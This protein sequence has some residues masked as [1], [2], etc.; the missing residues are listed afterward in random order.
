M[1]EVREQNQVQQNTTCNIQVR[2]PKN[3]VITNDMA[4]TWMEWLQQFNWYSTAVQ[5]NTQSAERQAATLMATIGPDAITIFNTFGLSAEE[6]RNVEVIKQKFTDYFLPKS[7]VT[8]ER[9]TF[10]KM[11]QNADETFTEFLTRIKAQSKKCDFDQLNDSLL[12]DKI[13]IGVKSESIREKLS[14]EDNLTL[15]R[16]VTIALAS[17]QASK[18]LKEMQN[19]D[20]QKIDVIKTNKNRNKDNQN[21]I[22]V[23]AKES[24]CRRCG[25]KHMPRSCPAFGKNCNKCGKS[26][27]FSTVCKSKRKEKSQVQVVNCRDADDDSEEAFFIACVN[28][29]NNQRILA[30]T[31][32]DNC[33]K[34]H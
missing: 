15:D 3:L 24:D 25:Q 12:K 27:N 33:R 1:Q 29:I 23:T 9:Y 4:K 22:R 14:A 19:N 31:N 6:Q 17:E 28:S 13:V 2:P 18:Q 10:N 5:L 26:G 11:S 32:N 8:Y 20:V 30:V 16:A 34:Q 21:K 7:N